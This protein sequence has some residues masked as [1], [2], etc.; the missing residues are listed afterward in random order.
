LVQVCCG[1]VFQYGLTE[2]GDLLIWSKKFQK[3]FSNKF[4]SISASYNGFGA[5]IDD[6][7]R[8]WAFDS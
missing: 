5:A 7:N 2:T 1:K 8:V 3:S 4:K 6:K